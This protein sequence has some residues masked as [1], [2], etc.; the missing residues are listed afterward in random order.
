VVMLEG[1]G[2][3]YANVGGGG[4]RKDLARMRD[5]AYLDDVADLV[6]RADTTAACAAPQIHALTRFFSRHGIVI[7]N[8]RERRGNRRRAGAGIAE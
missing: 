2:F 4:V 8:R 6:P 5:M 1:L 7:S 3:G